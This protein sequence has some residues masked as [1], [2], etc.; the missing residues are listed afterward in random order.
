MVGLVSLVGAGPG[1]MELLTLKGAKRLAE[2]D[3]VLHDA[4]V[5]PEMLS[6]APR[7]RRFY[8]GRRAGRPGID[9][10]A[11]HALMIRWGLR[12]KRVVRLKCGD[13]FVFGRGGEEIEALAKAG[14]PF[15]VIPGVSAAL[16]APAL[17]GIP[18]TFRGVASAFAVV[19][20]HCQ[21]AWAPLLESIPPGTATVVVLMGTRTRREIASYLTANGW[22]PETPVAV[23]FGV[24]TPRC[25]VW[26]GELRSLSN[27]TSLDGKAGDLPGTIVVGAV[28]SLRRESRASPGLDGQ[29]GGSLYVGLR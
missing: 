12:G 4:L 14:V 5:D 21:E 3:L 16:A 11:I 24:S 13:P 10:S 8:V 29:E 28:V 17:A 22:P 2:A 9:Q 15:E 23:L 20:G 25:V 7:A 26:T 18:L 6:L 19:S 1:D 27:E